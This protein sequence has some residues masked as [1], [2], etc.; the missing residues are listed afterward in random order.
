MKLGVIGYGNA[1]GK[2]ADRLLRFERDAGRSLTRAVLAINSAEVD[3]ERLEHIP[4][5]HR[6]LIGQTDERVKGHGVGGD[7]D[8]GAEITRQ[9]RYEIDRAL[10]Q[11]PVYDVS[12]F[13]VVAGLGGGTGSGGAPELANHI[14]ETYEEPVYGLGILPAEEEGGRAALNAA[15]SLRSFTEATDNLVLFDNHAW[16]GSED[17]VAGGY[18]RTNTEIVKRVV[19]LLSA[20]EIDGSQVSENAMDSGD[21]RRTLSTGGVS[22]IAYAE[23]ELGY[24][25]RGGGG[26]LLSRFRSESARARSTNGADPSTRVSGLVRQAVQSRLTCPAAVESAERSLVVVSGPPDAFSR[27]GLESGRQWLERE[28]DS[29]EVL[30]GDDPR[31]DARTLSAVV[32]LSNVTEVPRVDEL[33]EQAT[34]AQRRIRDL[35]SSRESEIR[36]LV[37]DEGDELEPL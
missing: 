28:T 9:D 6:F 11:V 8:L 19:T 24:D 10:D 15:R 29:V 17:S 22:T 34:G 27:K 30:A 33:Q 1:G 2:V 7:P 3:L 18:E 35:E 20:G 5:E 14:R 36:D 23:T 12:G 25:D 4:R 32:L 13:L 21:I 16:R 26:G 31:R 37:T